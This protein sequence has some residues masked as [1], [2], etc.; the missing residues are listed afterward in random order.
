MAEAKTIDGR[1][2][3]ETLRQA[4]VAE[5]ARLKTLHGLKPGLAVVLMG[6]DPASAVYVRSKGEQSLAAGMHSVTHRL[7]A[8]T[9]QNELLALVAALNLDPAIHGILVQLPLSDA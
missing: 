3:A 9:P 2:H 5:V 8:T 4:V 6:D 1:A 7:A